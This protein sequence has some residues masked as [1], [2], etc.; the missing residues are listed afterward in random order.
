LLGYDPDVATAHSDVATGSSAERVPTVVVDRI[1]ALGKEQSGLGIL[2][3]T[4]PA[5]VSIDGLLGLDFL[6]DHRLVI[7]FRKGEITLS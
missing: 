1:R 3:H 2:C 5:E 4:L 6:R 7:D